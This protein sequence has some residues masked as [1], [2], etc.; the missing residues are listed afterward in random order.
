MAVTNTWPLFQPVTTAAAAAITAGEG[1]APLERR[2][3]ITPFQ[4]DRKNDFANATGVILIVSNV[5]QILGTRA[6]SAAGPGELPFNPN[7]GSLLYLLR[8]QK[9]DV[10]RKAQ[11]LV[12]VVD[13]LRRWEPRALVTSVQ[14]DDAVPRT[15]NI[16]T[17]FRVVDPNSSGVIVVAENQTVETQINL[18]PLAA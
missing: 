7:F 9:I 14:V 15:L 5:Q 18:L 17:R 2:G 10:V 8:H 12:Y 11:A 6:T 1:G 13:A 16:I 3:I 4:R